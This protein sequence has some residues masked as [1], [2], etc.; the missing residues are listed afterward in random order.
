MPDIYRYLSWTHTLVSIA[1]PTLLIAWQL[2]RKEHFV[3]RAGTAAATGGG[4]VVLLSVFGEQIGVSFGPEDQPLRTF[5]V[6][7]VLLLAVVLAARLLWKGTWVAIIMCCATGYTV[8]NIAS[9]GSSL[10]ALACEAVFGETALDFAAFSV[11]GM[12]LLVAI[13]VAYYQL[14]VRRV[15]AFNLASIH[16]RPMALMLA[17]VIVV[18]IGFDVVVK[19]L[20]ADGASLANSIA[21]RAVHA[22][23]CLFLLGV[24]YDILC[25]RQL[26]SELETLERL[27]DERARQYEITQE[28]IDAINVRCHDIR[29]NIQCLMSESGSPNQLLEDIMREVNVYDSVVSTNNKALD[30][31]LTEKS[32][33]CAQ[34][35]ITLSCMVDGEA[36]D[37]MSGQDTYA[38]FGNALDNAMEAVRKITDPE[39][40]SISLVVS[41]HSQLVSVHVENY[42]DGELHRDGQRLLSTK[43]VSGLHGYGMRS[44]E[45]IAERYGGTLSATAVGDV[46]HLNIMLAS[47]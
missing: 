10:L 19:S 41:Q 33:L 20:M 32:L 45:L 37:F 43:E 23:I 29:Y 26:R 36:L 7:S 25:R 2:P 1:I 11:E 28:S 31:V 17:A 30:T 16:E 6:F 9:G 5:L 3:L 42:F 4:A 40:R 34:E 39:R 46:F 13:Y 21:L 18:V 44:M 27:Q 47:E 24:E 22:G 14:F 12:A 35:G 8:Q 15:R 38:L